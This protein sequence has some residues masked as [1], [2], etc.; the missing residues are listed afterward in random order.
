M[1][2]QAGPNLSLL[3]G[4]HVILMLFNLVVGF[5]GF[6]VSSYVNL[7]QRSLETQYFMVRGWQRFHYVNQGFS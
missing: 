7:A 4:R 1:L 6:M 3:F 5:G 2:R